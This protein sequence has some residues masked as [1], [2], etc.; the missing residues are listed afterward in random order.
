MR[1]LEKLLQH[2]LVRFS[3]ELKHFLFDEEFNFSEAKGEFIEQSTVID[4]LKNVTG[5]VYG[6]TKSVYQ[7]LAGG[8]E[9]SAV[10]FSRNP[11]E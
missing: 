5:T 11:A 6:L 2:P 8:K 1:Y 7:L 10:E 9:R 3:N 4:N